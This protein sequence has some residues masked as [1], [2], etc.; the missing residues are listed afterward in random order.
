M[1]AITDHDTTHGVMDWDGNTVIIAKGLLSTYNNFGFIY[2]FIVTMNCM[3][4]LKPVSVKLQYKTN[5]IAY[6][7][8]KIKNVISE[9]K[10]IRANEQLLHD[11]YLQAET[12]ASDVNVQPE[13]PR[14]VSRQQGREN[15]EHSSAEEYHRRI[16]ALP[17]LD[18]LIQ[19]MQERFGQHQIFVSKL[20]SLAPSLLCDPSLNFD[21]L[22]EA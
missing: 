17:L 10:A 5:D 2:S 8:S 18:H 20:L 9:L 12:L 1:M 4:V 21:G 6:A 16:T 19:Q 13:A 7:Y 22:I 11:W 14:T 15:V 3:S